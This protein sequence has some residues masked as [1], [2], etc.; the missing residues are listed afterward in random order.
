MGP[1][2]SSS[3]TATGSS[4]S[5]VRWS[6]AS[7]VMVTGRRHYS[8][9]SRTR[10]SPSATSGWSGDTVHGEARGRFDFDKP[11]V[12]FRQIVDQTL[13]LKPTVIFICYGTNESFEGEAG[14]E[15]FK[16]GL[17]KLIDALGI[18]GCPDRAVLAGSGRG[19]RRH[20]ST[21]RRGTRSWRNTGTRS[22]KS[23]SNARS[24]SPIS[25]RP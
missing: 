11:E 20:R 6:S 1:A 5:A 22:W 15:R 8:L 3:R 16:K 4:G 2:R 23:R 21:R 25:T 13:A 12:C 9:A 10:R 14:I 18:E 7:S 24:A 19:R 17:A